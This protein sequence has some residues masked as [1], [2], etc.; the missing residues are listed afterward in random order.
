MNHPTDR[1]AHT[2]AFVTPVV[3][4]WLEPEIAQCIHHEGSIR[5]PSLDECMDEWM[6][7]W[8]DGWMDTWMDA[9]NTCLCVCPETNFCSG[10]VFSHQSLVYVLLEHSFAN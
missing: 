3:V 6:D 8:M 9:C 4:H 5:P 1:I 2:T 7:G 10:L